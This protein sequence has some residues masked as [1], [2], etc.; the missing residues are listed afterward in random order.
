[1][2]RARDHLTGRWLVLLLAALTLGP[3][4]ALAWSA[5]ALGTTGVTEQ[6]E[7]T[8]EASA[9]LGALGVEQQLEGAA[10]LVTASARRPEVVEALRDG[11]VTGGELDLVEGVAEQLFTVRKGVVATYVTDPAGKVVVG[12]P[13]S[14]GL[15]GQE[16]RD[17]DWYR[18]MTFTGRPYVSNV[19]VFPSEA[20][21]R[22]VA[23]A[24]PVTVLQPGGTAEVVLGAVVVAFDA[25]TL[26]SFANTLAKGGQ[27]GVTIADRAGTALVSP[28]GLPE[29]LSHV[30]NP[31]M[32]EALAGRSGLVVEGGDQPSL[33]AYAPVRALGWGVLVQESRAVAL[34]GAGVLRRAVV[35]IAAALG[36]ILLGGLVIL[37][38]ALYY[39]RRAEHEVRRLAR[40]DQLTGLPNR[41]VWDEDL[42]AEVE[43]A[44]RSGQPFCVAMIDIDHFKAF[45]DAYGHLA[46]D[47]AL[48][49]AARVWAPILRETDLVAR[50]GGE[51][52]AVLLP[53]CG[54]PEALAV[55]DRIRKATP[56]DLTA[57]G[58]VAQWDGRETGVEL[59]GRADAALYRAKRRRNR[60]VAATA[61]DVL[62]R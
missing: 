55:V 53:Q 54:M 42:D 36:I 57:S 61:E 20:S 19:F 16:M 22:V 24:S 39:R 2:S 56:G 27:L 31:L 13:S 29:G 7:Q 1:M 59:T 49:E 46:G 23:V 52:F 11:T 5:V 28:V 33:A 62:V 38:R 32:S 48:A 50:Y 58:G 3:L 4:V 26:Q 34:E 18:G 40:R 10:D 14:A 51:E 30:R 35:T 15:A 12:L 45:N 47:F 41:R 44:R 60:V 9:T 25:G 17:Q 6:A 21:P 37:D 8:L 43:R